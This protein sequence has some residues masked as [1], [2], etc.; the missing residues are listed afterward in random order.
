MEIF[1]VCDRYGVPTGETVGREKAHRDGVP[2]RTAHVWILRRGGG[3][4]EVLLQKRSAGKDSF[5]GMYDTSSAGHIPAGCE[6]RESALRDLREELGIEARGDELELIGNFR[7]E[8]EAE[9]HGR[10]FRD[11]EF[12]FVYVLLREVDAAELILQPEEIESV[13]WFPFSEVCGECAR[14]G[15]SRFCVPLEGLEVLKKYL[16]EGNDGTC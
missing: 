5:P 15:R 3:G 8:Y 12:V 4:T 11:N 16:E 2:H 9:F 14:G 7:I 10:P 13:G 6:P 1:D